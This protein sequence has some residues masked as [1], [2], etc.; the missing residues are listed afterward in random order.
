[1]VVRSFA[2]LSVGWRHETSCI[3]SFVG[4]HSAHPKRSIMPSPAIIIV[5]GGG[6]PLPTTLTAP[7]YVYSRCEAAATIY[8]HL[9]E[10]TKQTNQQLPIVLCL[11]AGTA[12]LSQALS[13][14]QASH[15]TT[16]PMLPKLP[17]YESTVSARHLHNDFGIPLSQIVLETASYDTIGNAWFARI[18]HL[19]MLSDENSSDQTLQPVYIIT[20]SFH[21]PR[22]KLIFDKT[23]TLNDGDKKWE[24]IYIETADD[25]LSQ[26]LVDARTCR[27]MASIENLKNKFKDVHTMKDLYRFVNFEHRM[28]CASGLIDIAEGGGG[29]SKDQKR[30]ENPSAA[31]LA[32]YGAT[33]ILG[34]KKSN[35]L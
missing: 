9:Q 26:D 12:H 23:L 17:V 13:Q 25:G 31:V 11:S 4:N 2:V 19:E 6:P 8:M 1:M 21:M 5:L 10:K 18:N 27:E 22:S 30:E 14:D 33:T 16:S 20:S 29:A 15:N 24:R 32:S 3:H 35:F 28:Y 34:D 7:A